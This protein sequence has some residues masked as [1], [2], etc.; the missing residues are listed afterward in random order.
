MNQSRR[1]FLRLAGGAAAAFLLPHIPA[2][3]ESR[4][5]P[6][7]LFIMS[8]DHANRTVGAYGGDLMK[9]PNIDRIGREGIRF[10]NFFNV[11]S[12]CVPSRASFL[13]GKLS[14]KNGVRYYFDMLDQKTHVTYPRLM[15]EG[16][17]QTA[18][19]GKWHLSGD[20]NREPVNPPMDYDYWNVLPGQGAYHNPV[21][22]EMGEKRN[23]EGYATDII[24]DLSIEWLKNRDRTKPFLLLCHH[25]APHGPFEYAK[26]H[27]HLFEGVEFPEPPSFWEDYSTKS[28]AIKRKQRNMLDLARDMSRENYPTGPL[29][30]EGMTEDEIKKAAYQKY[31]HDYLRTL[32]AVDESV[33]RLLDYLQNDGS[34]DNTIVVYTSDQGMFL[35]DHQWYDKRL[36]YEESLRMPFLVRYPAE[37]A[38]GSVNKDI[39]LNIDMAPTFLDMAGLE[40]PP[41][42]QGRSIRPLLNGQTPSDWRTSMFY[43]WY[44]QDQEPKNYGVRTQDFKL[45]GYPET[46]EWELYDLKKDPLEITNVYADPAYAETVEQMKA[47]LDKLKTQYDIADAE[48]LPLAQSIGVTSPDSEWWKRLQ[49]RARSGSSR[50]SSS[51]PARRR[52]EN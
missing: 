38:A 31:V 43:I 15:R 45:I 51:R 1:D 27:E 5:R 11:N 32:T 6:N 47:E 28:R 37:I 46:Q 50:P 22:Y 20:N 25:K 41:D 10:D 14:H 18:L 9:T 44:H 34:L 4:P 49:E 8:D 42:M 19:I 52:P 17:Y 36:M 35:G 24:T 29:V 3:Q 7:V 48:L 40:I 16:G 13:T 39:S 21:L 2:A 23:Y 33:G 30:T 26:R 12:L